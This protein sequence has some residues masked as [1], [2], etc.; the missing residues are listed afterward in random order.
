MN[1]FLT[2][3]WFSP[4]PAT[5]AAVHRHIDH[6]PTTVGREKSFNVGA[7]LLRL[8]LRDT[9]L[10]GGGVLIARVRPVVVCVTVAIIIGVPHDGGTDR[11][12]TDERS[13]W[14]WRGR[15]ELKIVR[16]RWK[17]RG[18]ETVQRGKA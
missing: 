10:F 14:G 11:K 8:R 3:Q 18:R 16:S 6:E 2:L 12:P 13:S 7:T 9:L 1:K 5:T 4:G 15:T 17:G